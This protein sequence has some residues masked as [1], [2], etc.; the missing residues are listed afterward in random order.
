M[1][2]VCVGWTSWLIL[3]IVKPNETVNWVMKT[4]DFN[5]GSFWL[6]VDAPAVINWLAVCGYSLVWLLYSVVLLAQLEYWASHRFVKVAA[7]LKT[8]RQY[9]RVWMKIVDLTV[10]TLI[11][12]V[13]LE[14]G[15]PIGLVVTFTA[16]VTMNAFSCAVLMFLPDS[17]AGLTEV[18]V[19]ITFDFLFAVAFPIF[20]VVCSLSS[21][22][23]SNAPK[24]IRARSHRN[25]KPG[26]DGHHLHFV[27]FRQSAF[28]QN[29]VQI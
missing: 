3:L 11:L 25:R 21:L 6:M 12:F 17:Y 4:G 16:I 28:Y 22:A 20:T 1:A 2:S 8:N 13:V 19:D 14:D 29:Q 10:E 7:F 27:R 26:A 15:S 18:I 24:G 5:N 9:V 23:W